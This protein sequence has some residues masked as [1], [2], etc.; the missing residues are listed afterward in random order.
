MTN[1]LTVI[2]MIGLI[3]Q[4]PGESPE[5]TTG[6]VAPAKKVESAP[7]KTE[8]TPVAKTETTEVNTNKD[9]QK[10]KSAMDFLSMKAVIFT[11]FGSYFNDD[12]KQE[13]NEFRVNR[14]LLG[15]KFKPLKD[16]SFDLVFDGNGYPGTFNTYVK[17]AFLTMGG[18]IPGLPDAKIKAGITPNFYRSFRDKITGMRYITDPIVLAY[19]LSASGDLGA[20]IQTPLMDKSIDVSF[21]ISNGNG[22]ISGE[23]A[24]PDNDEQ[25]SVD[26]GAIYHLDMGA[27]IDLSAYFRY[28]FDKNLNN[29]E[30]TTQSLT[31]AFAVDAIHKL[32]DEMKIQV[33]IEYVMRTWDDWTGVGGESFRH[34]V[35]AA[36]GYAIVSPLKDLSAFLRMDLAHYSYDIAGTEFIYDTKHFLFGGAFD[37]NKYFTLALVLHY[38]LGDSE[39]NAK[40]NFKGSFYYDSASSS[41]INLSGADGYKV[42]MLNARLKF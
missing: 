8:V 23:D 30:E 22:N 1:I 6:V 27:K 2:M 21:G 4:Q 39:T 19:G 11:N 17:Y 5:E 13:R 15:F 33:G 42:L 24:N 35:H 32:S 3:T 31:A 37:V 10:E 40:M 7:V 38:Y 18:I 34:M 41:I 36:S 29:N 14:T 28:G 9:V 12:N 20:W 26:F 25:K 16:F